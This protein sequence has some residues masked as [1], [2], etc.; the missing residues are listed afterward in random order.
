MFTKNL[1]NSTLSF[2]AVKPY[3]PF[4]VGKYTVTALP[5]IHSGLEAFFYIIDDGDSSLLY[6]LDT[7][8]PSDEVYQ[9]I[10]RVGAKFTTVV[11]E[12]CYGWL[13]V[14]NPKT[15]LSLIGNRILRE[16]LIKIGA[17]REDTP[18]YLTHFS[19]NGLFKDGVPMTHEDMSR[20]A[21]KDKMLVAYDGME[22]EI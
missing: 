17:V 13:P 11:A 21:E 4:S 16:R 19:H 14:E 7:S 6:C 1:P 20:E 9:Y 12:C 5:A 18:W 3:E 2:V 22:I 15:H 8:L 10:E